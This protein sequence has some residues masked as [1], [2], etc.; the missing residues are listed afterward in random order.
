MAVV[1]LITTGVME[2][3]ALGKSLKRLF[4]NDEFVN[5]P[6]DGPLPG[7]TSGRV[8]VPSQF[9]DSTAI[10]SELNELATSL[11]GLA[12][13]PRRQQRFDFVFVLEDLELV[14]QEQ[15]ETVVEAFRN[16]VDTY[17]RENG[18]Q[19]PPNISE[20]VR[21]QC[22]FHLFRPL[23]E[24]YFFGEPAAIRRAGAQRPWIV[25]ADFERFETG[26]PTYLGLPKGTQE[27]CEMPNRK[28]HPKHYLRFLCDPG[29]PA[30]GA[31]YRETKNGVR[32]LE[33]LDWEQVVSAE[34]RC[35]FLHAFLDDLAYALGRTLPFINP[36]KAAACVRF[37]GPHAR[38][39]RN[40]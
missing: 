27:V 20:R 32:A 29:R 22:S 39:L 28:L 14:N 11:V 17:V 37:A 7:F 19:L 35:P 5:W 21:E 38:T 24:A 8:L 3:R 16:A 6:P 4:P 31:G 9:D 13:R 12:D 30:S 1:A 18:L 2:H 34:P 26:D 33:H 25:S 40:V 10:P 15:P 36:D 23:T